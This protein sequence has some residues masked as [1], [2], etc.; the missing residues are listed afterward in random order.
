MNCIE[1]LTEIFRRFPGIGPRQA[2]RFVHYLLTEGESARENLILTVA[3]LKSSA[4]QCSSCFRFFTKTGRDSRTCAL[5]LDSTR[6]GSSLMVVAKDVDLESVE[7]SRTYDGHYFVLGNTISFTD[8]EPEKNVRMAELTAR[9]NKEVKQGKLKEIILAMS[10]NP[11]GEHTAEIIRK[12]IS[13]LLQDANV[14]ISTLG[15][16][17]STGTELEYSDAETIKNALQNRKS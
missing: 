8:K 1:K 3:E 9:I 6:A 4:L 13:P 10:L 15:R 12:A 14:K 16:G 17:L 2:R 5:C 11:E 7:K